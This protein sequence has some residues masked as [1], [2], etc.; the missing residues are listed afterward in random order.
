MMTKVNLI[1]RTLAGETEAFG[2]LVL[3]YQKPIYRLI[4]RIM[5]NAAD[6]ADIAQEVFIKAYLNLSKLKDLHKFQGWL[7]KIATNE[8]YS[9]IRKR[10]DNLFSL[11]QEIIETQTLRFPPAP[12]EVIVKEELYQRVMSAISELPEKDKKVIELFY[13]EEKSYQEIQQ[14]LGIS[15]SVLGWRLSNARAKLRQKL[16]AAY[17]GVAFWR[18]FKWNGNSTKHD[19]RPIQG[20]S[21]GLNLSTH[22]RKR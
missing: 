9:W 11:E 22:P 3:Q 15:K 10:Q 6:A 1:E 12:D 2:Q 21:T 8:C 4:Y 7:M 14:Q 19:G 13:L 16:Q 20:K 5:G 18:Y 17:H